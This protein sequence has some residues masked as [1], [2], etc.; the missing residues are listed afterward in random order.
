MKT[1]EHDIPK[2]RLCESSPD[3]SFRGAAGDE[4]SRT[5]LRT[6]RASFLAWLGMTELKCSHPDPK[7]EGCDFEA[8]IVAQSAPL[9]DS[10]YG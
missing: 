1:P 2:A 8:A 6:F 5:A 4:K 10:S 3:L 7:G 9:Y